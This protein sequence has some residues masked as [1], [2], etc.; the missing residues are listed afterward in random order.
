MELEDKLS[1]ITNNELR[2]LI[3]EHT[4]ITS[5]RDSS[6]VGASPTLLVLHNL[7]TQFNYWD[8]VRELAKAF[9]T[10]VVNRFTGGV[11]N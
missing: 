3:A 2:K 7:T 8:K 10:E 6:M 9:E 1:T 4:R 11:I 5:T